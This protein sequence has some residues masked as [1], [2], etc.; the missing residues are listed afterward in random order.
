[1]TTQH[2]DFWFLAMADTQFGMFASFGAR[3][4]GVRPAR[5][6]LRGLEAPPEAAGATGI[7]TT[8]GV[9]CFTARRWLGRQSAQ[10]GL[11]HD[12]RKS[13]WSTTRMTRTS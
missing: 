3:D 1:M 8:Y 9:R 7:E 13:T 12:L 4:A 10:A 2:E 11:R 5:G 6:K